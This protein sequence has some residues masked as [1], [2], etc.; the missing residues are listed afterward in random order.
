MRSPWDLEKIKRNFPSI[1]DFCPI[2]L[3]ALGSRVADGDVVSLV[4]VRSCGV[5]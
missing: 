5:A 1:H 3:L 2:L 4:D